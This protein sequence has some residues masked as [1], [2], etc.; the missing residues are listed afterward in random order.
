MHLYTS[1]IFLTV[2]G[3]L[4]NDVYCQI[5]FSS[6]FS[7]SVALQETFIVKCGERA[8]FS[9]IRVSQWAVSGKFR[10]ISAHTIMHH[11]K[12]TVKLFVL[13]A[14]VELA[15]TFR[16]SDRLTNRA[17]LLV[18]NA[19]R[20]NRKGLRNDRDKPLPP[21]LARVGGNIE[22]SFWFLPWDKSECARKKINCT[23]VEES[24]LSVVFLLSFSFA[25][26]PL[27]CQ[28]LGFNARQR[29][30]F[31]NAVMR[32]GMPPQDAFTNQWLVRDLRGKSE[33]EFKWVWWVFFIIF[34]LL[35]VQSNI[36]VKCFFFFFFEPNF[37]LLNFSI[38]HLL[39]FVNLS[40]QLKV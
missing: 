35:W 34:L 29:K 1:C 26:W 11:A 31:L 16:P 8:S 2:T 19:R 3:V 27:T 12:F 32:Y 36:K 38:N 24:H 25:F 15:L 21:L 9:R 17:S 39:K 30:A 13:M 23:V 28:V 10:T 5:A 4:L 22:V 7:E 33:K 18:A 14:S 40:T 37:C 6:K 20:P